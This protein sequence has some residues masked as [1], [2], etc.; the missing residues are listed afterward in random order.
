MEDKEKGVSIIFTEVQRC[1]AQG[2]RQA[3]KQA[4]SLGRRGFKAGV[5][6]PS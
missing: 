5:V 4:S 6:V 3:P 1:G 2:E